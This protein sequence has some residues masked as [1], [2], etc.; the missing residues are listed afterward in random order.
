MT[1]PKVGD[2]VCVTFW[3]HVQNA[4]DLF[5]CRAY[6]RIHAITRDKITIDTWHLA[7][8][9]HRELKDDTECFTLLR[10]AITSLDIL[11]AADP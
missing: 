2:V 11:E 10:S 7:H 3:D 1:R 9:E 5:L 8:D 4:D 6:G